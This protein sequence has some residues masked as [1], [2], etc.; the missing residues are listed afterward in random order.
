M[1]AL[2]QALI[3]WSGGKDSALMLA[4]V[5]AEGSYKPLR[6]MTTYSAELQRVTMHGVPLALIEA[7][8]RAMDLPLQAVGLPADPSNAAYEA[9]MQRA[10]HA[11]HDAGCTVAAFGDLHLQDIRNYREQMLQTTPLEPVFPIW[12]ATYDQLQEAFLSGGYRAIVICVDGS[13]LGPEW[14][15][16][17]L[18]RSFFAAL[19]EGVDRFGEYGE[20]HTFVT[21]APFFQRPVHCV[22][23]QIAERYYSDAPTATPFWFMDLMPL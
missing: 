23:G 12:Q 3:N 13:K 6:L 21:H 20:F 14:L 19:P 10:C 11:A 16:R 7:Q 17:P 4:R 5:L 22:H 9:S 8:A 2:P 15:G 18:D 1:A